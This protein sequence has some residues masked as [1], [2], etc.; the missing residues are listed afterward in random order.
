M[1]ARTAIKAR[2]HQGTITYPMSTPSENVQP[3]IAGPVARPMAEM[4]VATPFNVPRIR[5]ELAE[6]VRRMV[7]QGKAKMTIQHLASISVNMTA[8]LMKGVG[9][10][11]VKGTRM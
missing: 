10:R 2:V 11:A 7:E 4:E 6:L 3:P 1:A 5:K 9:R 8:C